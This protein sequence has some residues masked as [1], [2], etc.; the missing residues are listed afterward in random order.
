M[1][2]KKLA[3]QAGMSN[4]LGCFWQCG[5]KDLENF[6][7][8]IRQDE[9]QACAKHYLKIMRDAV[10]EARFK[11]REA[12]LKIISDYGQSEVLAECAELIRQRGRDE[13]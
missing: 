2:I 12:C 8:L 11:E 4:M 7:A 6:A 9:A 1:N 10:N 13:H 3:E 5:D